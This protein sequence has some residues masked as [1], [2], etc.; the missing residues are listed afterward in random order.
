MVIK[1]IG[2]FCIV[3]ATGTNCIGQTSIG[4]FSLLSEMD[5]KRNNLD[6]SDS[7]YLKHHS[8]NPIWWQEWSLEA[9]EEAVR[10]DKPIFVSVGYSSCHWCH[11]MAREAF[12]DPETASFLNSN[13]ICF[14]VDK[15]ERPDID[16]F[17]MKYIVEKT[18]SGGWPLNVFMTP[19]LKPMLAFTYAPA[20]PMR[21][22]ESLRTIAKRVRDF[23]DKGGSAPDFDPKSRPPKKVDLRDIE[24]ILTDIYDW[25]YGGFGKQ[26]KFP[27]HSTLLFMLYSLS[28]DESE[29]MKDMAL[30][31]LKY[32]RLGGLNDHLQGGIFR[33]CVDRGWKIPHFE[34]ML[35][36]QAMALWNYSLA[37]GLFGL[38]EHRVMARDILGCLEE[39]FAVNGLYLNSIDADTEGEEGGTYVWDFRGLKEHLDRDEFR[40]LRDVY[41]VEQGGNFEGKIHLVK[42][43]DVSL[44]EI[45]EKLLNIR[46]KRPQP[47]ADHKFLS[48]VN[49][50][51]ISALVQASK[52]LEETALLK[53]ASHNMEELLQKFW[54]H[55]KLAH[56]MSNGNI[57]RHHYLF[58]ASACLVALNLLF[59]ADDSWKEPM[60]DMYS[61]L[62]TFKEEEGWLEA[63]SRDFL[64]VPASWYDHPIPSSISLAELG[65]TSTKIH[66]GDEVHPKGYRMPYHS[67][68][69]NI[70]ELMCS[71]DRFLL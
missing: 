35:Y 5:L 55:D 20:R 6:R 23:Y 70:S 69:Y 54:I 41:H 64:P 53:R 31:T 25:E 52:H 37:Y 67:D 7:I 57:Q 18:G 15:E 22:R 17:L 24:P 71:E 26:Q 68:I 29:A 42:S 47:H 65:I 30:G 3:F 50:L 10:E 63:D 59:Q 11:V 46:K 32:M 62:M 8:D 4:F 33:Y 45:E 28:V 12:S 36:D 40:K 34:K 1:H 39:S 13:F 44:P 38:E 49:A 66:T 60:L 56:S 9:L 51:V 16:Q 2:Q 58:D 48:G 61:Y 21:G 19:E 43:K 27:P 14:K